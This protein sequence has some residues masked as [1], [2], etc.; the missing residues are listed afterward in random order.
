M[1]WRHLT[2]SADSALN[3]VDIQW[4]PMYANKSIP[5]LLTSY[6]LI[7]PRDESSAIQEYFWDSIM[8]KDCIAYNTLWKPLLCLRTRSAV[9]NRQHLLLLVWCSAKCVKSIIMVYQ[10]IIYCKFLK[11]FWTLCFFKCTLCFVR[12]CMLEKAEFRFSTRLALSCMKLTGMFR[13][14]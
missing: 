5:E 8:V 1:G 3:S 11:N 2:Q 6:Q 12:G 10:C 7:N 14:C 9:C 13:W 4:Y